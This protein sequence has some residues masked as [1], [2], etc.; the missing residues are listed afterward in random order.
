MLPR[1]G[2]TW[3]IVVVGVTIV[4]T[5]TV[6]IGIRIGTGIVITAAATATGTGIATITVAI[7][8]GAIAAARRPQKVEGIPQNIG[9]AAATLGAHLPEAA[10]HPV[11]R[12]A[13]EG[14]TTPLLRP[15]L[16]LLPQQTP[17]VGKACRRVFS[18]LPLLTDANFHRFGMVW[19]CHFS[20]CWSFDLS[21][22]VVLCFPFLFL[23]FAFI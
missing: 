7:G 6:I 8:I 20:F 22:L 1:Q 16:L 2:S 4:E 12:I 5:A 17:L 11:A 13:T 10:A 3:V 9:D 23:Y 18:V 19:T 21:F 14:T 15:P